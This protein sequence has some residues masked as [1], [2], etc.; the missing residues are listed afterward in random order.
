[1]QE[2]RRRRAEEVLK[3]QQE[4]QPSWWGRCLCIRSFRVGTHWRGSRACAELL[5]SALPFVNCLFTLFFPPG[6]C[7]LQNDDRR[8]QPDRRLH[9]LPP[10][11]REICIILA[12]G[13]VRLRSRTAEEF[14]AEARGQGGSSLHFTAEQSV[15]VT[16]RDR[17]SA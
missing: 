13:L 4:P 3:I 16:P 17:R 15:C 10:H 12:A 14:A 1:M 9:H 11:L 2:V 7:H 5:F 8:P 6:E